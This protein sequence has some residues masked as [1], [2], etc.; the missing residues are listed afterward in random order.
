MTWALIP[1]TLPSMLLG[2]FLGLLSL[3]VGISKDPR[4][5]DG[6]FQTTWRPRF[7]AKWRYSTTLGF[8]MGIHPEHGTKV[9]AHEFVHIR[10]YEDMNLLGAI[11]GGIVAFWSWRL[12]LILWCSSGC[13]WLL[14]NF[15]SGWIRFGDAYYGSEHEKSAYAQTR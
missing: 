7:A 6:V 4:F 13:L 3:A 1:F 2:Q 12:G 11:I 15:L 10:Q 9:E 14:P 5:K 8:W